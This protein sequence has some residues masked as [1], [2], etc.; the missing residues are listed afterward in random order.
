MYYISFF[1]IVLGCNIGLFSADNQLKKRVQF[2][3]PKDRS[4]S[5]KSVAS[6]KSDITEKIAQKIIEVNPCLK[7][8]ACGCYQEQDQRLHKL[9]DVGIDPFNN[10]NNNKNPVYCSCSRKDNLVKSLVGCNNR[11]YCAASCGVIPFMFNNKQVLNLSYVS[12]FGILPQKNQNH[13]IAWV[14]PNPCS[15]EMK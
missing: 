14:V 8:Y 11:I 2:S 12:F 4:F 3:D 1:I 5:Q 7:V 13:P 6:K 10:R 9:C 15:Q